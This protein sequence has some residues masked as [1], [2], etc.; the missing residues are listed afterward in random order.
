MMAWL[1]QYRR[2]HRERSGIRTGQHIKL[3]AT[4]ELRPGFR[5]ATPGRIYLADNVEC[6][7]GCLLHAFGGEISIG[8]NSFLGPYCILYGH[9]GIEIGKDCLIAGHTCIASSNH[10]I[11]PAGVPIR[12]CPDQLLPVKI[13][14]DVWMGF[15]VIILGGVTIGDGAVIGA[16]SVI[17]KDVPAHTV[18]AGNPVRTLRNRLS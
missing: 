7:T 4:A 14:N 1:K 11:P 16:G 15:G 17:T 10:G 18:V 3:A 2:R 9:G 8:E 6:S 12:S 5:A 13:G